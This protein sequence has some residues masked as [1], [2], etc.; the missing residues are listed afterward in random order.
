MVYRSTNKNMNVDKIDSSKEFERLLTKLNYQ[1]TLLKENISELFTLS[2]TL[3]RRDSV[4]TGLPC[5]GVLNSN[6]IIGSLWS[7]TY[8]TESLNDELREIV[9]HFRELI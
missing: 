2:N 4:E 5:E 8:K 7:E 9:N 1:N 3:K 6:D